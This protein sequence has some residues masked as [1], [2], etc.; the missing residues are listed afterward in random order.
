MSDIEITKNSGLIE[1][2]EPGDQIMAD[3]RFALNK[4]LEGTGITIAT[5]HFLC[6]DG[7]FT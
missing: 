5:P 7:Q 2:L 3:K 4:L 6:S 1:L